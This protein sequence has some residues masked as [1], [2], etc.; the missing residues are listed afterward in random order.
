VLLRLQ[1]RLLAT[2]WRAVNQRVGPGAVDFRGLASK[3]FLRGVDLAGI[4]IVEGNLSV[5]GA[6]F[7]RAAPPN[8]Q[9]VSSIARE[10]HRAANRPIAMHAMYSR[11]ITPT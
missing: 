4:S 5:H 1:R 11:V 9:I 8:L 6:S 3:E 2:H 7:S 10:R